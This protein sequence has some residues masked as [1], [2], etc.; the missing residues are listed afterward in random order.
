MKNNKI[1]LSGIGKEDAKSILTLNSTKQTYEVINPL[2]TLLCS[3]AACE[4][5]TTRFYAKDNN[6]EVKDINFIKIFGTYDTTG[7]FQV[8]DNN[9]IKE[10]E[11]EVEVETN[12]EEG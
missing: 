11:M 1:L 6:I 7:F 4:N 5:I 2:E 12:I 8:S 9:I 3:L 10:I